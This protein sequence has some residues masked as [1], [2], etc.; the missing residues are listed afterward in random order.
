MAVPVVVAAFA[1]LGL[2]ALAVLAAA[3]VVVAFVPGLRWRRWAYD[4]GEDQI[5]LQHGTFAIRRTLVPIRRVQHVETETGPLQGTF[6]L[7]SVKFHTAAGTVAIPA[8]SRAEADRVRAQVADRAQ[9]LD[10]V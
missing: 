10:D 4:I 9:T 3:V 6:E 8:L 7:A 1:L 2:V 5:D